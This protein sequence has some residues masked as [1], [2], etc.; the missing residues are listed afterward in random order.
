[1]SFKNGPNNFITYNFVFDRTPVVKLCNEELF[2]LKSFGKILES[3]NNYISISY[4]IRKNFKDNTT[5]ENA[6]KLIGLTRQAIYETF[7]IKSFSIT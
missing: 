4:E 7:D 6:S 1:M 2:Q 5:T 3:Y